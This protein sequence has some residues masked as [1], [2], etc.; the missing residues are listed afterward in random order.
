M[1]SGIVQTIL[2]LAILVFAVLFF[3]E[4]RSRDRARDRLP[5]SYTHL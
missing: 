4:R 2:L 5:V 3:A 1:E